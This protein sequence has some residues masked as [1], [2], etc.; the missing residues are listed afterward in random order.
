LTAEWVARQI[1]EAFPWDEAPHYLIRDRDRRCQT[2]DRIDPAR[3]FGLRQKPP[4]KATVM[5]VPNDLSDVQ[6]KS[7]E[8]LCGGFPLTCVVT[9]RDQ[10][11]QWRR[12]LFPRVLFNNY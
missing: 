12:A 3:V 2:A 1:T 5:L 4:E 7:A 11:Y 6:V 8:L 9:Y 10:R